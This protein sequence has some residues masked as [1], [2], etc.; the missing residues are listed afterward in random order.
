MSEHE[1][2]VFRLLPDSAT[3]AEMPAGQR[4]F[5]TG[6]RLAIAIV[7]TVLAVAA[8]A[9]QL[10][11][12]HD[13]ARRQAAAAPPAAV[14]PL[15]GLSTRQPWPATVGSC[16]GAAPLPIMSTDPLTERTRLRLTVG[17]NGLQQVDLDT[18]TV[19]GLAAARLPEGTFVVDLQRVATSN[20]VTSYLE[21]QRCDDPDERFFRV[22]A[23]SAPVEVPDQS[24]LPTAGL[25]PDGAGGI[26]T[27]RIGTAESVSDGRIAITLVRLDYPEVIDLPVGLTPIALHARLVIAQSED[28]PTAETTHSLVIYDAGSGRIVGRLGPVTSITESQGQVIWSSQSCAA[29]T[30]CP[31]HRYDL[32]SGRTLT[33]GYPLPT[34]TS[35][36]NGILSLDHNQLAFQLGRAA[37]DPQYATTAAGLP[38]DLVVLDLRTGALQRV[39]NLELPATAVRPPVGLAFSPDG[40]W[41]IISVA[42]ITGPRLLLWHA[43]LPRPLASPAV[44]AGPSSG[45]FP[46]VLRPLP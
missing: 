34:G 28:L 1:P 42:G 19:T 32:S 39:P 36:A 7:L 20:P 27:T 26:W 45:Q 17:G 43:G 35:V 29:A 30:A 10:L 15:S 14:S 33:R 44:L 37:P 4:R 40:S 46:A 22:T 11:G 31:L 12:S 6:Q 5:G 23:G 25:F 18:G 2:P 9:G 16:G 38:S 8:L 13:A 24:G 21:T 3:E 41:L